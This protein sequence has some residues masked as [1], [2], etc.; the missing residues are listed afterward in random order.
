MR[1]ERLTDGI[2]AVYVTIDDEAW[3]PEWVYLGVFALEERI[4]A[5][6]QGYHWIKGGD[7]A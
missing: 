6:M 5:G 3:A 7:G 1:L 2:Y 4:Q